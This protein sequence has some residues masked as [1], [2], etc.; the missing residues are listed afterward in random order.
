MRLRGMAVAALVAALGTRGHVRAA[1]TFTVD[2]AVGNKT[3]T[4]VFDAAI[5]ERITAVSS[6]VSA[7]LTV[8]EETLEGSATCSVPLTSIRVD[9][10]DTKSEHFGEWATNKKSAP[11]TCT[12]DL[13]VPRV[14]LPAPI[15]PKQPVA[16]ETEGIFTLCGRTRDDGGPERIRGTILYLPAGTYGSKRTLRIRA[17][18]E[19]FDRERY[20]VSPKNTAGWLARVQQLADVVATKGTIEVNVFATSPDGAA[21]TGGAKESSPPPAP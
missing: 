18:I 19:A 17:H 8:D 1:T 11:A 6:A 7:T 10:D 4:A 3:F 5:G 9:N 12:F 21:V 15:E 20:G 14:Q 16:L 2:P 13:A